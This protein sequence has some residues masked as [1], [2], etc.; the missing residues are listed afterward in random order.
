MRI[1]I[2]A[3]LLI[4]AFH[5]PAQDLRGRLP[6]A[7]QKE[8]LDNGFHPSDL[9]DLVV[10]DDYRSTHNGAQ[11]T[12]LRQRWQGIEVWNGDIAVHLDAQGRIIKVN[13]SAQRA[14]AK[15]ANSADPSIGA[16]QALAS[17]WSRTMP[18]KPLP[19]PTG[20][21]D[22]GRTALFSDEQTSSEPVRVQL[23]LVPKDDA[24][25]L[26]WNV[27][28]YT[29]DGSHWWNVRIDA[30][31][32]EELER[33]DWVSQCAWP[34]HEGH[35]DHARV[36]APEVAIPA[37]LA[38]PNDYNIY[39]WPLESPSHGPRSIVNAPWTDGGIASPFGWHDT[40][41]AAGAEHTITRG[42]NV[43]AQEDINGNNGTGYSPDGGVD[44]D[45]DFPVDLA[46][47]PSTYQDAAIT[48]LFYWNNL[49]HDVIYQYGFDE[50]A[51]NFQENNYGRGGVGNDYVF[52]DALDGSGTNNANFGTPP[53]GSNPRMQMFVWTAPTPDRTG[54]FDNGIIAHEYGHGI[55]NRLVA[56]PSNVNCLANAEQMGEGW[57]DYFSL[58]MTIKT[59]DAAADA[60]GI[61]TYALNQP[62]TGVGIRPAPYSTSFGVNNYTYANTNSGVSQPHGIGFVWCTMLWEMTWELIAVYGLDPDI[63]NGTGGNNIAMQ[64]VIDG[65]KLTPCNPGFVDARDAILAADQLTYGGANQ[66]LIW[67]AF[68]RRGLGYS[69]TQGSTSNRSDQ[70]EA[71]DLPP[72][73]DVGVASI[74]SPPAQLI[75]CGAPTVAVT[76][77]LRNFGAEAQTGFPVSYAVNG[78]T[79]VV[80]VFS[81]TLPPGANVDF[82]FATPVALPPGG[83]PVI[84]VVTG[85]PLDQTT[86]NDEATRTVQRLVPGNETV[87][88]LQDVESGTATPAGWNLQNPD[89]ATTWSTTVL[90]NGALCASSRA[91]SINYYSYNAAGQEDR[92]I[93]P[94]IDLS[95][96]AATR[97]RFHHAYAPYSAGFVD[98]LRVQI[99]IDC[100][101]TWNTV[102]DQSGS[103]LATAP[104][105]TASWQPAN[106]NQWRLN[107]IDLSAFDGQSILLRFTGV[108][109]YGN[110]LYLD[111]VEVSSNG[112]SLAVDLLLEGAYDVATDRMRD[113]LRSQGLVPATEPYTALGFTMA[114]G[115]GGESVNATTLAVTGDNAVVDW[116]LVELRNTSAP[117]TIIAT[118]AAL[119]QRDGNVVD[120]DGSSPL[121]FAVAPGDYLVAVRHRNHLGT[122]SS[123]PVTLGTTTATLDLTSTSTPLYGTNA[124]KEANGRRML[125]VGDVLRDGTL[126]YVG[127]NNDRDPILQQV[128]GS[129]PTN[130]TSPGYYAAD[131]NM[132]GIV[133]YTGSAND[134]DPVLLNI[135]G[136]TP[137]N[138]RL[139]QLP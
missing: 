136:S 96:S 67:A 101:V 110:F 78:G 31:T 35:D 109:G 39:P 9:E 61:G 10:K 113:D 56:G 131:V 77:R 82:T 68:A 79:P 47:A 84:E 34:G 123:A 108:C 114:G 132:D 117:A 95:S 58:M 118:R 63:Y 13:N 94:V 121:V 72:A 54:D 80:E 103:V 19:T 88:Y 50:A 41:G 85:L 105:S 91:W 51:G 59:G 122:M 7:L 100:G 6:E 74:L 14:V 81:G 3:L 99:S 16:A 1:Q 119:V 64:L 90:T 44:L 134:R 135:G 126:R 133:R 52:A 29:P 70:T 12:Y 89:N 49:M 129:V 43:W 4:T 116:V 106:C 15:R 112:V 97:L 20:T 102:F 69:A 38:A 62:I 36:T 107:D 139:E 27:N 33:N 53:D 124:M 48:N 128:G 127:G 71:F 75:E 115:G 65:M 125:W 138:T 30:T 76:A 120:K 92:L 111:N 45:F 66:A 26:A 104:N 87:D 83:D 24:L 23:V 137:T 22:Q 93:S 130:T 25:R 57:S 55:S 42:N 28:H 98:G 11:H 2:L 17:V 73:R 21:A 46:Q 18:G 40:D 86:A 5:L 32:G 37:M 8:L 60:R